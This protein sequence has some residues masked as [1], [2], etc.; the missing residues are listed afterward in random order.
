MCYPTCDVLN[1]LPQPLDETKWI[2]L[3]KETNILQILSN[4]QS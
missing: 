3:L 1:Q 2:I 4:F